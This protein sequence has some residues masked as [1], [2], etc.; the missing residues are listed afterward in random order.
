LKSPRLLQGIW[1]AL[2]IVGS[3]L[4][5]RTPVNFDLSG[6]LPSAASPTQRL[7]V[8]QLRDGIGGRLL[9]IAISGDRSETRAR[10][11]QQLAQRLQHSSQFSLVANGAPPP[12]AQMAW[13]IQRRYLLSSTLDA[14]TFSEAGLHRALENDLRLLASP[15]GALVKP[16][17]ARDPT[18]ESLRL[19]QTLAGSST[20]AKQHDVWFSPDGQHALLLAYS[21]APG[22][23]AEAQQATLKTVRDAFAASRP[24]ASPARLLLSGPAV[25]AVESRQAIEH[26]SQRLTLASVLLVTLILGI[27]YRAWRPLLYSLIP[28]LSGL[29]AGCAAVA[30]GFGSIH[31]ITL[32]FGAVLIG[33]AVDYPAYLFTYRHADEAL[34]LTA[35]RIGTTLKL[36]MLTT[37]IGALAMLLSGLDGLRQLGVLVAVGT[38]AAGLTTR[39]I[40]PTLNPGHY[41]LPR[42]PRFQFI[43]LPRWLPWLLIVAAVVI[44]A[45]ADAI[46]DDD[47]AHLSPASAQT[48][49]TDRSLR[50]ELGAPE[51]RY[52]LSFTALDAEQA[53]AMSEHQ[54]AWLDDLVRQS[55]IGGYALAAQSLPS[56]AAQRARLAALPD[57]AT[58]RSNL[59]RALVGLP[60]KPDAFAPFLR[61]LEAARSLPTIQRRDLDGTPWA[62]RVDALL[63]PSGGHWLA[64]APLSGVADPKR[65]R[66]AVAQHATSGVALLD[67][68]SDTETLLRHARDQALRLVVVGLVLIAALLAWALNSMRAAIRA[69]LPV[70]AAML[71]S[72][73]LLVLFGERLNLFHLIAL[74]LVL[75]IGLNYALFF[76]RPDD[77]SATTERATLA[78]TLCGATSL[79]AFMCLALASIPVLHAIGLSVVLGTLLSL[80][81]LAALS[82]P[83]RR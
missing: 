83:R 6:F 28:V 48:L 40:V 1:L 14:A 52:L 22:F 80:L 9:L 33:E 18:G 70:V 47:L 49:A 24:R 45:R 27:V 67:L 23:D 35:Q 5:A 72:V 73:A 26:A 69:L 59:Q 20:T 82:P 34:T 78:V 19:L 57:S 58:A 29:L 74:L 15:A 30:A 8:E 7:L 79:T 3:T 10:I 71:G 55:V 11:S 16:W 51:L 39:W 63:I 31:G 75:G 65:L 54:Q 2:V 38:L 13:L 62:T 66:A 64:L 60:F 42:P 43:Q 12:A 77:D 50:S 56:Q 41:H 53:L 46:W 25:F 61:E 37:A 17:I 4:L 21:R 81:N 68:K 44:L 76:Q 32:A 36:A